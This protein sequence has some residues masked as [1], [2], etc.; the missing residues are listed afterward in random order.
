LQKQVNAKE[1]IFTNS[2]VSGAI[3]VVVQKD[4]LYLQTEQV[5]D[6]AAQKEQLLKDLD[7]YKG[8]LASVEKKLGNEKFV[9][10]AKPEVVEAEQKKKEDA[11]AR[12]K[13]IEESLAAISN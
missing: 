5:I 8:F 11:L 10:N 12:I 3:S 7:Y 2:S 4:K 9:S 1:I 13:A 6:T